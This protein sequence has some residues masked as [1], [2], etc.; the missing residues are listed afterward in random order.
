VSGTRFTSRPT[1]N[2]S[3]LPTDTS[4]QGTPRGD[5]A[6]LLHKR[7]QYAWD[8]IA[9]LSQALKDARK[10]DADASP[11][12]DG[13]QD[14]AKVQQSAEAVQELQRIVDQ[15]QRRARALTLEL[16]GRDAQC[17]LFEWQL[18]ERTSE[19]IALRSQL[20]QPASQ[21][22]HSDPATTAAGEG[23][24]AGI[25]SAFEKVDVSTA[26]TDEPEQPDQEPS[27]QP[28]PETLVGEPRAASP[29][30]ADA[31]PPSDQPEAVRPIADEPDPIASVIQSGSTDVVPL[32]GMPTPGPALHRP[33]SPKTRWPHLLS[34]HPRWAAA[35]LLASGLAFVV[36]YSIPP[37]TRNGPSAHGLEA[38]SE[39]AAGLPG[40]VVEPMNNTLDNPQPPRRTDPVYVHDQLR[41]GGFGPELVALGPGTFDMGGT[42][43]MPDANELPVHSVQVGRFLIATTEVTFA[44]YDRFARE[45]GAVMPDD[46]GWGRGRRPVI[47]VS[48]SDA[49]AYTKW[50]TSQTGRRY[51]L[52]TE[53]EWEYAA[54]AGTTTSYWW[55][56]DKSTDRAACFDCESPWDNRRTA[57]VGSFSP[58]PFGL[59][60]TAGN[61]A[62]WVAD[63]WF[64]NYNGAPADASARRASSCQSQ[65]AR[66][67]AFNK[68][69]SSMRSSTRHHFAPGTR[70]DMLGFRV[71]RNI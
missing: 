32:P 62:E 66:G 37:D 45:T 71:A 30:S 36:W 16:T 29:V 56:A 25:A 70:I 33:K 40:A 41:S 48:W 61:V 67:G 65:V 47:G 15:M 53:A 26:A 21:D 8:E 69:A 6:N 3:G 38:P 23:T 42:Y 46:H 63:C 55:G 18:Y 49:V 12:S 60:D 14:G 5:D 7:L 64:S 27:T 10:G 58:N 13:D 9:H 24:A 44:E 22:G 57:P 20:E 35:Y 31:T 17:Q 2:A 51:R 34:A 39:L 68:P 50:L 19:L 59:Y 52:P 4:G 43:L 11:A 54:R 1:R 28:P